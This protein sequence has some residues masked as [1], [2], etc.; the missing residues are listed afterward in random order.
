[1]SA[2]AE[3]IRCVRI[4]GPNG[5]IVQ[6]VHWGRAQ[7]DPCLCERRRTF[8]DCPDRAIVKAGR[9]LPAFRLA[10]SQH[11]EDTMTDNH[12]RIDDVTQDLGLDWYTAKRT[13][14]VPTLDTVEL[15]LV[16]LG[17][18]YID[19]TY[20]RLVSEAGKGRIG[21][22]IREFSWS[23]FGAIVVTRTPD[24]YAVIDG[25]HRAVA[26]RAVGI[27]HV[28]AIICGALDEQAMDFVAI[29]TV[30]TGVAAIDKFRARVAAGDESALKVAEILDELQ[31][32]T[33]V[34]A[35]HSLKARQTRAVTTLEKMVRLA[36]RGIV[37]TALE[38][39]LDAQPDEPNLL[40]AFAVEVA[41]RAT[42]T[43]ID[44]DGDLDR[45]SVALEETDFES[46][47]LEAA[48]LV[49]LTGG[50]TAARGAEIFLRQLRKR[51][52]RPAA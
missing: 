13:E 14:P 11:Q 40:T 15:G 28:P 31:I 7:G 37:F 26:A 16:P 19:R 36:G 22:I 2:P 10:H 50:R 29:N 41:V 9:Q 51:S 25:Q 8:C 24:G 4:G 5:P 18:V 34:P 48:Q 35:G 17:D 33:D 21:R 3:T 42:A 38:M 23:R 46:L 6:G 20:Q 30:R 32:S 44:D 1:M 27:S 12:E 47:K 43:V 52:R 49:K 39:L 45:L